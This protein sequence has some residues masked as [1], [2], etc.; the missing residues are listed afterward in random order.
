MNSSWLF[1]THRGQARLK[2]KANT[3][4][5]DVYRGKEAVV[6]AGGL[7]RMQN[8]TEGAEAEGRTE[9]HTEK[10]QRCNANSSNGPLPHWASSFSFRKQRH[11]PKRAQKSLLPKDRGFRRAVACFLSLARQASLAGGR[12]ACML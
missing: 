4:H 3:L 1:W 5:I 11:R 7:H 10:R 8:T 9:V 12:G 6:K 2:S